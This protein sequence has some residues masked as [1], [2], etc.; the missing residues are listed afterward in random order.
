MQTVDAAATKGRFEVRGGVGDHY[1][2]LRTRMALERT[3]MAWVRTSIALIGFGF[4]IVQFFQR[5]QA[6]QG[7]SPALAP[8]APHYF[9]LALIGS[10]VMALCLSLL[11]YREVLAY[12]WRDDY[13]AIAGI[14]G[15]R[16]HT[17]L[18]ATASVLLLIGV[19]AFLAVLLR[20]P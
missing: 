18:L 8:R 3:A 14:P 1:A 13:K 5:L 17:P 19:F 2:W 12:L 6:M 11:Q 9:G 7:S 4:T 20:M 10:G 16:G 15:E